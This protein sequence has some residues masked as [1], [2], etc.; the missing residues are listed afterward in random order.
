MR[1]KAKALLL[2]CSLHHPKVFSTKSKAAPMVPEITISF[3][4]LPLEL[5]NTSAPARPAGNGY[6]AS[7]SSTKYRRNITD[8]DTPKIPPTTIGINICKND[9]SGIFKIY[10]AGKKKITP[11]NTLVLEAAIAWICTVSGNALAR[12]KRMAIPIAS[13]DT[14]AKASTVCPIFKPR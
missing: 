6:T 2:R 9:I 4:L 13:T 1:P 3:A 11:G 12:L 14:G 7:I 8:K 10:S 5:L